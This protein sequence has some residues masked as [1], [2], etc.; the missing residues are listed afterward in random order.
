MLPTYY[1]SSVDDVVAEPNDYLIEMTIGD[2]FEHLNQ[3]VVA[4]KL[5]NLPRSF[6]VAINR[7]GQS[8]VPVTDET[9]LQLG[10]RL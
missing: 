5:R 4:A 1:G 6:L 7:S 3:T 8:I 2:E 10:D 9:I